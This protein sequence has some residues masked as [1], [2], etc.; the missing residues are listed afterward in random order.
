M[1]DERNPSWMDL[2]D[3]ESGRESL[4]EPDS[5]D[6]SVE[7]ISSELNDWLESDF[8]R[9]QELAQKRGLV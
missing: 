8:T 7:A 5:E 2:V 9:V 4:Q 6:D 1:T 3:D